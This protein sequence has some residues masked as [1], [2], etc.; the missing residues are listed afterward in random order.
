MRVA[1]NSH[2]LP[3]YKNNRFASLLCIFETIIWED[4]LSTLDMGHHTWTERSPQQTY[5]SHGYIFPTCQSTLLYLLFV[6]RWM[7]VLNGSLQWPWWRIVS[8][9]A[10]KTLIKP[11]SSKD[12]Y[13]LLE[14]WEQVIIFRLRTGH[15]RLNAHMWTKLKLSTSLLCDCGQEQH[16][17][18]MPT[19]GENKEDCVANVNFS[20]DSILWKEGWPEEDGNLHSLRWCDCLDAER[21]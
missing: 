15:K 3:V 21:Q 8:L 7:R 6:T 13:Q 1:M 11:K 16:T 5:R 9:P 20:S 18:A 14:R 4:T 12:D 19:A 2:A 17:A 10:N